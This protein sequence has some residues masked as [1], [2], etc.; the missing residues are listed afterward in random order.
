VFRFTLF[1]PFKIVK[2]FFLRVYPYS[3]FPLV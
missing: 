3:D 2:S 1:K